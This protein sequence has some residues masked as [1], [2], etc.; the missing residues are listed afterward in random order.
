MKFSKLVIHI[1]V[2]IISLCSLCSSCSDGFDGDNN[3]AGSAI[4][5]F[6]SFDEA[7]RIIGVYADL[8]KAT[9]DGLLKLC[10]S[11]HFDL[12][13]RHVAEGFLTNA[14]APIDMNREGQNIGDLKLNDIEFE[15]QD[16]SYVPVNI[17]NGSV[18]MGEKLTEISGTDINY[19]ITSSTDGSTV[20]SEDVYFPRVINA[21]FNTEGRVEDSRVLLVNRDDFVLEWDE[22]ELNANGLLVVVF[23]RN[24]F[25]GQGLPNPADQNSGGTIQRAIL[26][27]ELG[28]AK[29]PAELFEGIPENGVATLT[30]VRGDVKSIVDFEEHTFQIQVLQDQFFSI[31]FLD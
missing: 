5:G 6:D 11:T 12:D 4:F 31:G 10:L 9:D 29:I 7:E 26:L 30:L 13:D 18:E 20:L 1:I 15:F 2:L 27:D 14:Y 3:G 22:D 8:G 23:F 25:L 17:T 28:Q 21:S 19:T 24:L 16:G